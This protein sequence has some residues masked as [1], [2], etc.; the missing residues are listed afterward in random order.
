MNLN[1]VERGDKKLKSK[2]SKKLHKN[3]LHNYSQQTIDKEEL[4]RDG[5]L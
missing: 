2:K 3:M 5:E 4:A 1:K